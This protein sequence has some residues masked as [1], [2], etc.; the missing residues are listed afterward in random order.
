MLT[1]AEVAEQHLTLS[2]YLTQVQRAIRAAVPDSS[3]VVAELSD[4]KRRPNGHCYMD[5]LESRDGSEVAKARCT[6]FANVAGK[7]LAEWQRVTGGLPQAGMNVLLKVRAEFSPQY[8]FSLMVTGIDPSY[9][10][11]D[12]EAKVQQIIASLKERGWFDLQKG[13]PSPGGFWRVAVVAPHEAA[14]L[15]DFRRDAEVMDQAGVCG[16]EYFGATFQGRDASESLRS[17][18]RAVHERHQQEAFDAVCIIRGGGAKADLAWLNDANVAAWVCRLPV[19]VFC[20]IGHEI[21]EC[22][23]DLVANRR[24]DTPSKV[25]GFI[26][27]ALMSEASTARARV[28][29]AN[30]LILR[31]VTGQAPALERNWNT[32]RHWVREALHNEHRHLLEVQ[33][34]LDKGR[35]RLV[36]QQ[37]MALQLAQDRF[38]RLGA[39]LCVSERQKT[40]LAAS[41]VVSLSRALLS[42]ESSRLTLA[43]AIFDKTN[44]LALL[45]RGFA[46]VRGPSGEIISSAQQAR[47]AGTLDLAFAD[48][49]V[50]ATIQIG[51]RP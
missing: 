39:G 5:I 6:M 11:G 47:A 41:Q 1:V 22:V 23:L 28:E 50:T 25:I 8:G 42:R 7:V 27:T 32:F 9:T 49:H 29:R 38:S 26:K 10:L 44:P 37:R 16:F 45:D 19:P 35:D 4:F 12:M 20:G 3:W 36:G 14:G 2:T 24:F 30:S 13:L 43:S 15:A 48:G 33:V 40:V 46:L 21:D 17:A 31:L 18:L 51:T 34:S